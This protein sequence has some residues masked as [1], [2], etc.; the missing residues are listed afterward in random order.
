MVSPDGPADGQDERGEDAERP[1]GKTIRVDTS[2]LVA[3]SP[4]AASRS[5]C[6]TAESTSSLSDET[7]G[8]IMT[9]TTMQAL[10]ALNVL[11]PGAHRLER[12]P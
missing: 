12:P 3:P 8:M 2:N 10:S 9:P 7:R 4:Y 6:G 1:A 11:A 5:P